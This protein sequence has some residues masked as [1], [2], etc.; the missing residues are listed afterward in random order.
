MLH[1]FKHPER[2]AKEECSILN[3]LPKRNCGRIQADGQVA[4][5]GWGLYYEEN[6]NIGLIIA[7]LVGTTIIASLIFGICWTLMRSDIQGAWGLSSYMVTT[8]ALIVALLSMF[9]RA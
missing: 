2:I 5:Q 1:Y 9:G 8:C 4:T 6:W 7:V 3:Q